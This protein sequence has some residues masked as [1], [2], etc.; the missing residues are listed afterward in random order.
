MAEDVSMAGG[1]RSKRVVMKAYHKPKMA[2]KHYH[3]LHREIV[4]MASLKVGSS[5]TL[6]LK[7]LCVCCGHEGSKKYN[8]EGCLFR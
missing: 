4:A 5:T 2:D 8:F 3:K 6:C 1:P 7:S